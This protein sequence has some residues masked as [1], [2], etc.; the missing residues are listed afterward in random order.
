[1]LVSLATR[2]RDATSFEV[3]SVPQILCEVPSEVSRSLRHR[4]VEREPQ[5][6]VAHE[7]A[8]LFHDHSKAKQVSLVNPSRGSFAMGLLANVLDF[9]QEALF[10]E[11]VKQ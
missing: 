4:S 11:T 7:P 6:S 5:S 1:M 10:I 3:S 2:Q 8:T 9:A